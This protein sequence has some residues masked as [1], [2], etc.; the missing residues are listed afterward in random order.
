MCKRCDKEVSEMGI[1]ES[2]LVNLPYKPVKWFCL[3]EG[4]NC[5]TIVRDYGI[6]PIYFWPVIVRRKEGGLWR[7][8]WTSCLHGYI[9]SKHFKQYK[10]DHISFIRKH[11]RDDQAM[12]NKIVPIKKN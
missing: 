6:S 8:G 4:C 2:D 12:L 7:G 10:T 11:V 9:C 3:V 5:N 1:L